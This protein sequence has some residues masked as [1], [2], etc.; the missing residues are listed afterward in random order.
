MGTYVALWFQSKDNYVLILLLFT[1]AAMR[2][3]NGMEHA[4]GSAKRISQVKGLIKRRL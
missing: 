3:T 1:I 4:R 2:P